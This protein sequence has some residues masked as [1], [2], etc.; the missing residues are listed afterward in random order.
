M[1]RKNYAKMVAE[2][3][4]KLKGLCDACQEITND[5]Q[6]FMNPIAASEMPMFVFCLETMAKTLRANMDKDGEGLLQL[7]ELVLGSTAYIV[8]RKGK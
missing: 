4:D 5:L 1:E 3:D 6:N 2:A 8:D 7:M